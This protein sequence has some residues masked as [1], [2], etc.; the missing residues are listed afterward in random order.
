MVHYFYAKTVS[1]FADVYFRLADGKSWH[2]HTKSCQDDKSRVSVFGGHRKGTASGASWVG[3]GGSRGA[4]S[5]PAA[6]GQPWPRVVVLPPPLAP[7]AGWPPLS[8]FLPLPFWCRRRSACK[9]A[10][11]CFKTEVLNQGVSGD[12]TGPEFKLEVQSCTNTV[13]SMVMPQPVKTRP[14]AKEISVVVGAPWPRRQAFCSGGPAVWPMEGLGPG[15]NTGLQDNSAPS[16]ETEF[17]QALHQGQTD[18]Q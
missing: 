3:W 2:W 18:R 11:G 5:G 8:G 4:H 6:P 16:R 17:S 13:D 1:V 15:V 10:E 7:T 9:A 12:S 14:L